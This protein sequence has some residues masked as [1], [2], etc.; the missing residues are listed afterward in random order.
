MYLSIAREFRP[1]PVTGFREPDIK[2]VIAVLIKVSIKSCGLSPLLLA[3]LNGK[4]KEAALERLQDAEPNE[5]AAVASLTLQWFL[6]GLA[7]TSVLETLQAWSFYKK[8]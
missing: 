4:K 1:S 3:K 6:K 7:L 8:D 2:S 5:G